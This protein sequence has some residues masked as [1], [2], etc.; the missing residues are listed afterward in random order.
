MTIKIDT[1]IKSAIAAV[2]T[3]TATNVIAAESN[4]AAKQETEKCY[5]IVKAGMNDCATSTQSC[6]GS[7]VKDNQPDAFILLPKGTCNK[8]V[9]GTVKT[10]E[11]SKT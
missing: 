2:L 11:K 8:I 6:A 5:G 3:L 1:K 10:D 7:A 4:T 9:G